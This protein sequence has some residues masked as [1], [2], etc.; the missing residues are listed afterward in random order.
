MKRTT[1]VLNDQD[2]EVLKK[3]TEKL[4]TSDMEAIRRSLR[5]MAL[6][7]ELE[8][9]EPVVVLREHGQDIRLMPL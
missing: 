8:E 3:V 2:E 1:V 5:A 7:L 4:G 6:L 9:Q